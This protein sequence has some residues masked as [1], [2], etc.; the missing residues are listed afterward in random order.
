MQIDLM[1]LFSAVAGGLVI[2]F[3]GGFAFAI[4]FDF[5]QNVYLRF[6]KK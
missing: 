5:G 2:G 4:V 1:T 3:V 6:K